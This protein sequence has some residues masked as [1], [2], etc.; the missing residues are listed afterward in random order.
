MAQFSCDIC[1]A[2]FEQK[3]RLERHMLTSHPKQAI[4]AADLEKAL[5]GIEFPASRDELLDAIDNNDER[6]GDIAEII[7]SLPEQQYRDAAEVSR[8]FG[9]LRSHQEKPDDQPSKK[10]GARAM[11]VASAANI[12]SVFAGIDFPASGDELK[13]FARDNANDEQMAIIK[14]F[15]DKTYH[16]MKDVAKEFGRVS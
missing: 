14:Q 11:E 15:S 1:D 2:T 5:K 6:A 16:S 9:G 3:S 8:A 10:G 12:A 7:K 13:Q 4:S